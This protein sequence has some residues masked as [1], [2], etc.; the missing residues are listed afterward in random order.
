MK[1][2][3]AGYAQGINNAK[4]YYFFPQRL[5]NGFTRLG[6]TVHIFNDRDTARYNN[7]RRSSKLG[8]VTMNRDF[9]RCCA[10]YDPDL[11]VLGHCEM[12]TNQ[13]L[14]KVYKNHPNVKIIYTNVDPFSSAK[15][16]KAIAGRGKIVDGV[17]CTTAGEEALTPLA[18]KSFTAFWPNLVDPSIDIYRAYENESADQSDILFCASPVKK[19]H[20]HRHEMITQ[21]QSDLP[22]DINFAL[23]GKCFND[24]RLEGVDYM[25]AIAGTKMG[26]VINKTEDFYLYA[27]DRMTHLMANGVLCL[28]PK[29]PRYDDLFVDGKEIVTYE[30]ADDLIEKIKYH[31]EH[32]AK[33][34]KI[35]QK[36]CDKIHKIF[37]C[38]LVAQ[39]LIDMTMGDALTHD[40]AWPTDKY[41][42]QK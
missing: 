34:K 35:A 13:T 9:I 3:Y 31:K 27:S 33:R 15:T 32:D 10:E 29:S 26:I 1:I 21:L 8:A 24:K 39:Y 41:S 14:S 37:E 6:H 20:D 12:I 36:G 19:S 40:Y 5:I 22:A 38:T 30:N 16:R 42:E 18:A 4:Q 2:L 28:C 23:H 17:F 7:W 11:I 25:R